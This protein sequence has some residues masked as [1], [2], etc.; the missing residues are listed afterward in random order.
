MGIVPRPLAFSQTTLYTIL[1]LIF[2]LASS[3]IPQSI[4]R[5]SGVKLTVYL[6]VTS[7]SFSLPLSSTSLTGGWTR[8]NRTGAPVP[9]SSSAFELAQTHLCFRM[10]VQMPLKGT[11]ERSLQ[12]PEDQR[13]NPDTQRHPRRGQGS[14]RPRSRGPQQDQSELWEPP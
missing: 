13:R 1:W 2:W 8:R 10:D 3:F 11:A 14:L 7:W 4:I 6:Q 12:L 5:S 9:R